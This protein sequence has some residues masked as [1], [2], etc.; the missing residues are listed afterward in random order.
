MSLSINGEDIVTS[1]LSIYATTVMVVAAYA[2]WVPPIDAQTPGESAPRLTLTASNA[3]VAMLAGAPSVPKGT[4]PVHNGAFLTFQ[5]AD[6]L[7][8]RVNVGSGNLLVRSTDLNLPGIAGNVTLGAAYNSLLVGSGLEN[9]AFGHG[10]RIRAGVDVRLF[11]ADD[12]TVTYAAAEGVVGVFNPSGT[13]YASPGEVKATLAHD[14]TGWKLTEHSS[15]RALSFTSAGLLDKTTDRNGNVTDVVYG[16]GDQQ[17][18]IVSD[19]G[20]SVVR[21]GNTG[22]GANGFIASVSQTGTDSTSRSTLYGYDAAGN[23][24]SI[25]DPAGNV[26]T[27]DYDGAHNL[28]LI[29]NPPPQTPE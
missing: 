26:F 25:T 6:R 18:R 27:F 5:L 8:A 7:E 16:A 19:R 28:T 9:G 20:P 2:V 23:L 17:A 15:G 3:P 10:W 13:G 22:Y 11:P 12:G 21:N 29:T 24:R 4:G 14:G 1:R